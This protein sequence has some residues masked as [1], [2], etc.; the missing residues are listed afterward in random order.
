MQVDAVGAGGV[1][2]VEGGFGIVTG[3]GCSTMN[4]SL[5]PTPGI[6]PSMDAPPPP[7]A[8][9]ANLGRVRLCSSFISTGTLLRRVY[10]LELELELEL[11][12]GAGRHRR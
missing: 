5:L 2:V 10:A 8:P 9:A 3:R 6:A 7:P 11:E 1:A 4:F 12:P